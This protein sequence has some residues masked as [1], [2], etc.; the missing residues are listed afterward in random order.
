MAELLITPKEKAMVEKLRSL[1]KDDLSAYYDTDFN[2]LRWLQGHNNDVDAVARKLR[3][4]LRFRKCW[5]L[6][7]IHKRGRDDPIHFHW[8]D[9]LTGVSGK[10]DDTIINIEQAGSV[11]YWGMLQTHSPL[12]ITKARVYDLE[13]MLFNVMKHEKETGKLR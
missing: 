6:D 4:H 7:N 8:P 13:M 3:Y 11:D 2:L 5:D 1:V 10:M 9:G 12:E